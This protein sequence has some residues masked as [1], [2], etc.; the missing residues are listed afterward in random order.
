ME[1]SYGK[2]LLKNR[3]TEYLFSVKKANTDFSIAKTV[4][5]KIDDFPNIYVDEIAYLAHTTPATV[6]KF[7]HKIGYTGFAQI[8]EDSTS[9]RLYNSILQLFDGKSFSQKDLIQELTQKM[10][11]TQEHIFSYFDQSQIERIAKELKFCRQI[12]VFTGIH[13]FASTNYFAELFTQF[14]IT[15]FPINRDVEEDILLMILKETQLIFAI[16]LTG[17]WIHQLKNKLSVEDFELFA[18]KTVLLCGTQ[19]LPNTDFKEVVNF[20]HLDEIMISNYLSDTVLHSFFSLLAI[21]R[22]LLEE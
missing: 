4:L 12:P 19:N 6:S 20:S 15:G 3:L 21:N 11:Y 8:R 13:G 14:G 9:S 5:E 18:S 10:N 7:F 2:Y 22:A 16:S 1:I 17:E